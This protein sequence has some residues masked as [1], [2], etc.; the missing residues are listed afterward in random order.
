MTITATAGQTVSGNIGIAF[1]NTP[2]KYIDVLSTA[3]QMEDAIENLDA[4]QL[5]I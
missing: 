1:G 2:T 3:Q 4:I 5:E